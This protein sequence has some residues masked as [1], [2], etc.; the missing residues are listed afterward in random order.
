M[1]EL[2]RNSVVVAPHG[3]GTLDL[4]SADGELL[5]KFPVA[6]GRSKGTRWLDL[7][8]P[9][10]QLQPGDGVMILEPSHRIYVQN[11]GDE[12]FTS[13][14]N[15]DFRVS[16]ADRLARNLDL[17]LRKLETVSAAIRAKEAVIARAE[18]SR[19]E[20]HAPQV[21]ELQPIPGDNDEAPVV[22]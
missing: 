10:Q 19:S 6:A 5:A 22:E 7:C 21:A 8:G 1:Q 14:A 11:F 4:Y 9:G 17:R 20:Q 2:N 15:P 13:G 3:G 18:A 12:Q 16:G